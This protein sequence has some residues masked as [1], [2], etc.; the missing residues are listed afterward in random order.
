MCAYVCV[1]VCVCA[2]IICART[3]MYVRE[4]VKESVCIC[5]CALMYVSVYEEEYANV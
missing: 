5:A 3:Y 1:Y 2:D 4:N